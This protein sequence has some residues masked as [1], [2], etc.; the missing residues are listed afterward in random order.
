MI[1][2]LVHYVWVGG[3]DKPRD[4]QQCIDSWKRKLPDFKFM[5]WNEN[6]FPIRRFH[7]LLSLEL[8]LSIHC[9]KI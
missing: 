2:K 5:E 1:P 7:L 3:A 6:N 4:I 8:N 9:S